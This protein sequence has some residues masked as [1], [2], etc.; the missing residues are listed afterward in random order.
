MFLRFVCASVFLGLL[1]GVVHAQTIERRANFTGGGGPEGKCTI[2]VVVDGAAE[3]EIR[4]DRALLRNLFGQPPQWR[5]F[6]CNTPLPG[7][8]V[9]F[10]FQ[11]VDGRGSQKLI[12]D[13]RRGGPAVVRIDDPDNG[14]EGYTFDIFWQGGG[15]YPPQ[16]GPDRGPGPDRG[17]DRD[18]DRGR[19]RL[20]VDDAV[21]VC[22]DS[23][24]AQANDRL[25]GASID[26]RR[27]TIDDQPGRQDWVIGTFEARRGQGEGRPDLYSFSCSVDFGSGRVRSADFQRADR[28]RDRR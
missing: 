13:P 16:G 1:G 21:R 27:T 18:R 28:D 23:V 19:G 8:P 15:G 14:S 10:R 4:G 25:R 2:E 6:E 5:R 3:V 12:G 22:Q 26:F 24:R 11:G 7:N 9:N 17:R 20:S